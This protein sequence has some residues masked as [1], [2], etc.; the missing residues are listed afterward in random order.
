MLDQIVTL[1][2]REHLDRRHGTRSTASKHEFDG[3]SA[4]PS[5][6]R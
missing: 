2:I 3:S 1:H 4:I 5:W 6:W